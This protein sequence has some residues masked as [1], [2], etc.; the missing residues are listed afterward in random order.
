M[1]IVTVSL[2]NMMVLLVNQIKNVIMEVIVITKKKLPNY[3]KM[4]HSYQPLMV[5]KNLVLYLFGN[6]IQNKFKYYY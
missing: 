2:L 4:V 5:F 1:D 6:Q 3:M